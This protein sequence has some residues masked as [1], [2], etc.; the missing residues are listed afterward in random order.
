MTTPRERLTDDNRISSRS[1]IRERLLDGIVDGRHFIREESITSVGSDGY[2]YG[3][4]YQDVLEIER[5]VG[6]YSG[7]NIEFVSG[8]DYY[9][10]ASGTADE[11]TLIFYSGKEPD[12]GTTM[13]LDYTFQ[14]DTVV[15]LTNRQ[16]GGVLWTICDTIAGELAQGQS[17]MGFLADMLDVDTA[18]G[19]Y[20]DT[21]AKLVGIAR[22][23]ATASSGI[24]TVT[25]NSG[26]TLTITSGAQISTKARGTQNAIQLNM[27]AEHI[28]GN[29]SSDDYAIITATSGD[30]GIGKYM[31][32]EIISGFSTTSDVIVTNSQPIGGGSNTETDTK[33]R[34]RIKTQFDIAGES[35]RATLESL[36]S[37]LLNVSGVDYCQV[38]D[39]WRCAH[40]QIFDLNPSIVYCGF[41]H[42]YIKLEALDS[43]YG[44]PIKV[45]E[46]LENNPTKGALRTAIDAVRAAGSVTYLLDIRDI[47]VDV[48]A[49]CTAKTGYAAGDIKSDI[50]D[51]L[52]EY[53]STTLE[54]GDDVYASSL[55]TIIYNLEGVQENSLT[56][57]MYEAVPMYRSGDSLDYDM[58]FLGSDKSAKVWVTPYDVAAGSTTSSEVVLTFDYKDS[59]WSEGV[60]G[61]CLIPNGSEQW[62]LTTLSGALSGS[63]LRDISSVVG[64]GVT[65][66]DKFEFR[67]RKESSHIIVGSTYKPWKGILDVTVT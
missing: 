55:Q 47:L 25:N 23:G 37:A 58:W 20:L 52:E 46:M 60:D 18:S 56:L 15:G 12:S 63:L 49:T 13:F 21:L 36:R 57:T 17:N 48:I 53:I 28:L 59:L 11:N 41:A 64:S 14:T 38:Y 66:G 5:I 27:T 62:S 7:N 16:E 44:T 34:G 65:A 26:D 50:E 8:T 31:I 9:L 35:N 22:S 32:T 61:Q 29:G 33:L 43:N 4:A 19:A 10:G 51:A 54:V 67:A 3:F 40:E 30:V 1:D 45:Q 6:T 39:R 42:C 2:K 24:I